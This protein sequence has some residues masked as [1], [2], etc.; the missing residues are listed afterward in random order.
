[1]LGAKIAKMV[2]KEKSIGI[3]TFFLFNEHLRWLL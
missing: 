1:M 3:L 2:F